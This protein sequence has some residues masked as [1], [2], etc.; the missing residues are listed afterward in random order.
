VIKALQGGD[1]RSKT[2]HATLKNKVGSKDRGVKL[3][4]LDWNLTCCAPCADVREQRWVGCGQWFV[5]KK[6]IFPKQLCAT[7]HGC[8]RMFADVAAFWQHCIV[9]AALCAMRSIF[10]SVDGIDS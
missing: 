4:K 10:S 9:Y 3:R 6:R 8:S 2:P 1:R 5:K 7:V